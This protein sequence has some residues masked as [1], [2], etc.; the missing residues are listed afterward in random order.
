MSSNKSLAAKALASVG[1]DIK[2]QRSRLVINGSQTLAPIISALFIKDKVNK[3]EELRKLLEQI[4]VLQEKI[5]RLAVE[6][7]FKLLPE[8]YVAIN[9]LTL[10]L[11][12]DGYKRNSEIPAEIASIT[13]SLLDNI[14]IFAECIDGE[15]SDNE[16]SHQFIA[17][18]H[19]AG[20]IL[21][22][23][24]ITN[25]N[26][27]E[28]DTVFDLQE[29]CIEV[30][31]TQ[32]DAIYDDFIEPGQVHSIRNHLICKAGDILNAIFV[33]ERKKRKDTRF[34]INFAL[35]NEKFKIA[36]EMYIESIT[37]SARMR[38]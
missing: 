35:I 25:D 37:M 32:L 24:I 9:R 10:K 18:S 15:V 27:L 23:L 30:V 11:V 5:L 21:E 31:D 16:F 22:N 17:T 34:I 14:S 13:V 29:S 20:V 28:E 7:H 2:E 1:I 33:G 4:N 26:G 19:L 6:S 12:C 38:E 8:H 36:F 3:R